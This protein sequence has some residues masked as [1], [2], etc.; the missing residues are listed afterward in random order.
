MYKQSLF[1]DYDLTIVNS[2]KAFCNVYN[3]WYKN[4]PNFIPA[5]PNAITSYDFK[6][7]CPLLQDKEE[8]LAIWGSKLF[9]DLVE[10]MDNDTYPILKALN[11]KYKVIVCSIGIP[12]NIAYKAQWL[13]FK[14]KFINDYILI[15]DKNCTMNKSMVNMENA[16]FLDDIV[17]NL[18]SSNASKKVL[19]GKIYPWN[20]KWDGEK[21]LNWKE[22]GEKFL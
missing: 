21:C 15:A 16:I 10:F 12:S 20:K 9:F 18:E 7:I 22:V 13:E 2:I 14:L 11:E 4:H 8:K 19:F 3:I 17:S 1:I 6:C 5:N